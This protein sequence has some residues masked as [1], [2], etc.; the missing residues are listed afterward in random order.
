[1][2]K[3]AIVKTF[4]GDA[5]K[6]YLFAYEEL[7]MDDDEF[8]LTQLGSDYDFVNVITRTGRTPRERMYGPTFYACIDGVFRSY[9]QVCDSG[10]TIRTD[11]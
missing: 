8:R 4:G 10:G 2:A 5:E 3:K 9:L 7:G 1:M 11:R 6:A